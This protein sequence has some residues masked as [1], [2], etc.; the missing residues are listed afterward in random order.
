MNLAQINADIIKQIQILRDI[1][2]T[3]QMIGGSDLKQDLDQIFLKARND[4]WLCRDELE[5][6]DV[7][8]VLTKIVKIA[9]DTAKKIKKISFEAASQAGCGE[10]WAQ[11]AEK[12]AQFAF[13]VTQKQRAL[14]FYQQEIK[15]AISK[16]QESITIITPIFKE[17]RINSKDIIELTTLL[18]TASETNEL[19]AFSKRFSEL[20]KNISIQISRNN[21]SKEVK[22]SFEAA[23]KEIREIFEEPA[24]KEIKDEGEMTQSLALIA[25]AIE[26]LKPFSQNPTTAEETHKIIEKLNE[27]HQ[28]LQTNHTE[29]EEEYLINPLTTL[30]QTH[31]AE[32][33]I[34]DTNADNTAYADAIYA[35]AVSLAK[36][37]P[38]NTIDPIS[39]DII[40]ED[41]AVFTSNRHQFDMRALSGWINEKKSLLNPF[42][43][44]PFTTHRDIKQILA[45]AVK[46]HITIDLAKGSRLPENPTDLDLD[47][48]A[49]LQIEDQ[50]DMEVRG[51]QNS[52]EVRAIRELYHY[53]LRRAH[54]RDDYHHV[55]TAIRGGFYSTHTDYLI[56]R[57]RNKKT[58]IV[59]ALQEM[60]EAFCISDNDFW[61]LIENKNSADLDFLL[62][63]PRADGK[64]LLHLADESSD[65]RILIA[66]VN[67]VSASALNHALVMQDNNNNTPL[68][69]AARTL[70]STAFQAIIAKASNDFWN[71]I[72]NKN[73]DDLDSLLIQPRADG[74]NLLHL[75]AESLDKRILIALVNK[76]SAPALNHALVMKDNNNNTPLSLAAYKQDSVAFQALIAKASN[77]A[78]STALVIKDNKNITPLSWAAYKQ[79]SATFQSLISKASND[80]ISTA[81]VIKN[82]HNDTPLSL[83]AHKQD[84]LAFQALIAKAS[85]DA[86]STALVIKNNDNDTPLSW[87]ATKNVSVAF[88]ALIAK[89]SNDAISTA[90]V[91]KNYNNDTPLSLAAGKLS[92]VAFQAL[93]AKASEDAIS[94]ALVI[95]NNNKDTPLSKAAS[96][97]YS[98]F[99]QIL[100]TKASS[101]AINTALVMKNNLNVTPLTTISRNQHSTSFQALIAKASNAAINTAVLIDKDYSTPLSL[102]Y[103]ADYQ[104]ASAFQALIE[105]LSAEIIVSEIQNKDWLQNKSTLRNTLFYAISLLK[106]IRENLPVDKSYKHDI[107]RCILNLGNRN[108]KKQ[109]L[110]EAL[111]PNSPLGRFFLQ[112]RWFFKPS[113]KS[114]SLKELR[115]ALN[116][117]QDSEE[118]RSHSPLNKS[119]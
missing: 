19:A 10:E 97:P 14:H 116:A 54:F 4:L 42:T 5:E 93:I 31:L 28:L 101:D 50:I 66:L 104:D 64:N 51:L 118:Q 37:L 106:L 44:K 32:E 67:K 45:V 110:E 58:P 7:P 13:F 103:A 69:R 107:K 115:N 60:K 17:K 98:P 41:Y 57:V 43:Q 68:I 3:Q 113:E 56:T 76:V 91:I 11:Y 8:V 92:S 99:L 80:A 94:A 108:L 25:N 87:A 21:L 27:L 95:K 82:Y 105:K 23:C 30:L 65:K 90:L 78:I 36:I 49:N 74:K 79:D 62:I 100:I 6:N 102:R 33:K 47:A 88:Q 20:S 29:S 81:L 35:T 15:Q 2:V 55:N 83:A 52:E 48:I 96:R 77:E 89:A 53:G 34:T 59:T 26:Q 63:Q 39:L 84:S 119:K 24:E 16:A 70:D 9:N 38:I 86:I 111:N 1:Q 18:Q 109:I 12:I 40:P 73:S 112:P 61:N 46:N 117:M 75:A 114:G 85:N 72:E 22:E 71:L